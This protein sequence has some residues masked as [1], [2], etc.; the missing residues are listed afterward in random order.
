MRIPITEAALTQVRRLYPNDSEH[1][2]EYVRSVL[3]DFQTFKMIWTNG[4]VL[5]TGGISVYDFNT[6]SWRYYTKH[7]VLGCEFGVIDVLNC[8]DILSFDDFISKLE[9]TNSHL[10]LWVSTRI[11]RDD[12]YKMLRKFWRY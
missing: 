3:G 1:A 5:K 4:D 6:S 12:K 10:Q 11:I 8:D 7:V 2:V 9:S